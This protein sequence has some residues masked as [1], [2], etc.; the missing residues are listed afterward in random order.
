[1]KNNK[2]NSDALFNALKF[3]GFIGAPEFD[4]D[5]Y[6]PNHLIINE[7][8]VYIG[9]V[10]EAKGFEKTEE[11]SRGKKWTMF[12]KCGFEIG[13]RSFSELPSAASWF[14]SSKTIDLYKC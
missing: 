4:G 8:G 6:Q 10:L 12:K 11:V 14:I 5:I 1:M 7:I 13:H 2:L 3:A 9:D